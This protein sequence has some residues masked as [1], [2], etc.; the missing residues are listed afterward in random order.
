MA[1]K[2]K[3]LSSWGL[4]AVEVEFKVST[5]GSTYLRAFCAADSLRVE[6]QYNMS[7]DDNAWDAARRLL[8]KLEW[9]GNYTMGILRNGNHVFV[10]AI[11]DEE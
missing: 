10:R 8:E 3:L 7:R 5:D 4:Q 1:T 6:R 9:D 2:I 11:A